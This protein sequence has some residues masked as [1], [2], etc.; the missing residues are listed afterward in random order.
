[1]W[2][3]LIDIPASIFAGRDVREFGDG[4]VVET[5]ASSTMLIGESLF[6]IFS[7]RNMHESLVVVVGNIMH[8]LFRE[9]L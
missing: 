1:M 4:A 9:G 5:Q 7:C 2:V 3:S 6:S 8:K